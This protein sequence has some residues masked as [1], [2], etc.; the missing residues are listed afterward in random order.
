MLEP[1]YTLYSKLQTTRVYLF[2]F[3]WGPFASGT[4]IGLKGTI[5]IIRKIHMRMRTILYEAYEI[6]MAWTT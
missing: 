2:G 5:A 4:W 6:G 3:V 1:T